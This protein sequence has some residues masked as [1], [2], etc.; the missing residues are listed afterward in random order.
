MGLILLIYLTISYNCGWS[1]FSDSVLAMSYKIMT[2]RIVYSNNKI[3]LIVLMIPN[4]NITVT[5]VDCGHSITCQLMIGWQWI[6]CPYPYI[7]LSCSIMTHIKAHLSVITTPLN[8][9]TASHLYT[10]KDNPVC[11]TSLLHN[12]CS[13]SASTN[14]KCQPYLCSIRPCRPSLATTR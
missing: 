10:G 13:I 12:M 9:H 5:V 7:W 3:S 2:H 11:L 1:L 8:R 4:A 6:L 14:T